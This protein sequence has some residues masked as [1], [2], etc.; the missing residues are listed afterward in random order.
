MPGTLL[1]NE[2]IDW[3]YWAYLAARA[4]ILMVYQSSLDANQLCVGGDKMF[5]IS[6]TK[7]LIHG[8]SVAYAF[9]V[10]IQTQRDLTPMADDSQ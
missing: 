8:V 3:P 9:W 4:H 5:S 6:Y 2:Q 10:Y 1:Q 7:E